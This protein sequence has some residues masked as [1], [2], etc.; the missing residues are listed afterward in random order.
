[1]PHQQS[2][3][4]Q[5]QTIAKKV[6]AQ[7]KAKRKSQRTVN[8]IRLAHRVATAVNQVIQAVL[9]HQVVVNHRHR[10]VNYIKSILFTESLCRP[11]SIHNHHQYNFICIVSFL[12]KIGQNLN[13]WICSRHTFIPSN[14]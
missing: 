7:R 3:E 11:Q 4:A 1:M 13:C 9:N 14:T 6:V 8:G 5:M 2:V 12:I 10:Q